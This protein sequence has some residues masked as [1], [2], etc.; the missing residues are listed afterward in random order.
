[1]RG[2]KKTGTY[3]ELVVRR[4][5]HRLGAR[6]RLHGRGLPGKPDLV[7]SRRRLVIFVHGCFWHGHD[8][9]VCALRRSAPPADTYWRAKLARNLERDAE[10]REKLESDGWRV[11]I[12][13]ECETRKEDG[14]EARIREMLAHSLSPA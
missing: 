2:N 8:P 13:W 5:A 6:Y 14:L 7:L 1:M 9:A 4:V 3:P 12:I 11:E 10:V